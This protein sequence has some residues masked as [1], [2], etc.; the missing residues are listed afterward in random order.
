MT[1]H[2]RPHDLEWETFHDPHGRSTGQPGAPPKSGFGV[3]HGAS[4]D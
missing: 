3:K 2:I 4:W 1:A